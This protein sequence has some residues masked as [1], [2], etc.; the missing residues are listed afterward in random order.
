[1]IHPNTT[2]S[3][4]TRTGRATTPTDRPTRSENP[5]VRRRTRTQRITDNLPLPNMLN[6]NSALPNQDSDEARNRSPPRRTPPQQ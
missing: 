5:P 3:T 4:P 1:M 2:P 6:F